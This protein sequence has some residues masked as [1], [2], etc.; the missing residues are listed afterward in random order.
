M[1]FHRLFW[2][3]L[4]LGVSGVSLCIAGPACSTTGTYAQ[5][6]AFGATGCTINDLTFSNF[7]FTPTSTGTGVTPTASQVAYTLDNPGTSSGTGQ[8][9][10]G[11]EFNPDLSVLGIGTE[12]LTIQY[13]ITAPIAEIASIHLLETVAVSGTAAATVAEGPD[14][15]KTT[16]AGGCTFLPTLT[17]SAATPHQDLLGVGPFIS[18]HVI[19]DIN[20]TSTSANGSAVITNVRDSVDE[21]GSPVP[22]PGTAALGVAGLTLVALGA[23]KSRKA[24]M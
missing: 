6:Q 22:E 11:F 23:I 13:D 24:G 20:V 16:L 18:L 3:V 21:T 1:T 10:W 17:V 9:I 2:S 4:F 15:G 5:L 12:D 14:C 7:T 19:K 8:N